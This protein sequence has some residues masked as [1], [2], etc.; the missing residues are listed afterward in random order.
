MASLWLWGLAVSQ[1]QHLGLGELWELI[2]VFWRRHWASAMRESSCVG[3]VGTFPFV[4]SGMKLLCKWTK[5]AKE[6][7]SPFGWWVLSTDRSKQQSWECTTR[8]LCSL[9]GTQWPL[10]LM[11]ALASPEWAFPIIWHFPDHLAFHNKD[12]L[13]DYF[14]M[15]TTSLSNFVIYISPFWPVVESIY[16]SKMLLLRIQ[17]FLRNTSDIAL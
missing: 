10:W 4:G 8:R 3:S 5:R 9:P 6:R 14:A 1:A 13:R 7:D 12:N 2:S 16:V 15:L 11:L 17:L